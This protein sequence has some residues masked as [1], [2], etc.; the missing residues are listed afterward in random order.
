MD[1]D[2]PWFATQKACE[3]HIRDEVIVAVGHYEKIEK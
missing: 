1:C 2:G 3:E